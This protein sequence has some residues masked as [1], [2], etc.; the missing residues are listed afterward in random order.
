MS[1]TGY[2]WIEQRRQNRL[3]D[4]PELKLVDPYDDP[5]PVELRKPIT[6]PGYHRGRVP[7]NKGRRY[8]TGANTEPAVQVM[9]TKMGLPRRQIGVEGPL[10]AQTKARNH[11]KAMVPSTGAVDMEDALLTAKLAPGLVLHNDRQGVSNLPLWN[12][13]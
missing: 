4:R 13:V 11:D 7:A 12:A 3:R 9:G 8:R 10:W 5:L 2:E 1:M 6:R